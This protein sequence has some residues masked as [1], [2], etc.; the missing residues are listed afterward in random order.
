MKNDT[1]FR[2]HCYGAITASGATISY[3]SQLSMC[4]SKSGT[5]RDNCFWGLADQFLETNLTRNIELCNRISD[6]NSKTVCLNHF[7]DSPELVKANADL[8]VSTCGSFSTVGK[9]RCYN[10]VARAL[11]ASDPKKAAYICQKLGDDV[12]ISDCYGNV[13]FYSNQLVMDNYDYTVSMCNVL[14]LKRDDCLNRIVG[15]FIDIDRDKA[16][17][18]CQLMSAASSASCLNNVH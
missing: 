1:K 6:S 11:S 17:A 7:I 16:R 12:Q 4:E 15:V 18:A 13:W 8:A 10:D 5:D 2:E 3:D 9:S 14:T